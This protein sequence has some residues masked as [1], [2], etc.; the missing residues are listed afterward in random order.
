MRRLELR[1]RQHLPGIAPPPPEV[2][3]KPKLSESSGL[4]GSTNVELMVLNVDLSIDPI[5]YRWFPLNP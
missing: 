3:G 4:S 1:L 2:R 5:T